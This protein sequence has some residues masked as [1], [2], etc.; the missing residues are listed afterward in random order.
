MT[1]QAWLIDVRTSQRYDLS[2]KAVR[3]GRSPTMT[4]QLNDLSVSREHALLTED[5]DGWLVQN[6]STTPCAT[7]SVA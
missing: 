4:L 6:V 1:A 3:L 7:C 5:A 2:L